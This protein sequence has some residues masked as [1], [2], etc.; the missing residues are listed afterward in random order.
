MD[1]AKMNRMVGRCRDL[2]GL[3]IR[4]LVEEVH[5]FRVG[6]AHAPARPFKLH[7]LLVRAPHLL[8]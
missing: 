7:Y 5:L 3:I 4:L 6:R 1:K 2:L 8:H